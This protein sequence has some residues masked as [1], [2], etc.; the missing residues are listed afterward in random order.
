MAFDAFLKLDGVDGESLDQE[1]QGWCEVL[2]WS[3]GVSQ[4]GMKM[5]AG[6]GAGRAGKASVS[7][8]TIMKRIDKASPELFL[9]CMNGKVFPKVELEI[10]RTGGAENGALGRVAPIHIKLTNVLVSS[11]KPGEYLAPHDLL[12][13]VQEPSGIPMESLSLNFQKVE[14][15]YAAVDASGA[16]GAPIKTGWDLKANVKI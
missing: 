1:H 8:F 2:S 10:V 12:P 14:F 5:V 3:W 11:Y 13:A 6:V 7:S 4:P 15:A 9:R 16:L